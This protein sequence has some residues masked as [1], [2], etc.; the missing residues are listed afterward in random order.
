MMRPPRDSR[1]PLFNAATIF[2][3][4]VQGGAVLIAVALLYAW[5][6]WTGVPAE[7][8]RTMG[9]VALV[10]GNL[11]LIF[12][13]RAPNASFTRIFRGQNRALWWVVGSALAA[14]A[15]VVHWTPLQRL[16]GFAPVAAHD[17][18]GSFA[19][20][21]AGVILFSVARALLS[22]MPVPGKGS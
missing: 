15:V 19:T 13:H 17:L 2:A 8:A 16:F 6:Q 18:A 9:F 20:G 21:V 3:C 11:G 4:L 7:A 1:A 22:R 12:A 5:L 10:A 14:L